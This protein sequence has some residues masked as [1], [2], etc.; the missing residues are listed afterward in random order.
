MLKKVSL[1]LFVCM[2]SSSL[3]ATTLEELIQSGLKH[4]SVI[5]KSDLEIEL[6]HTKKIENQ[7]KKLGSIDLVGSYTHY[8]LPRTLAPIVP[9]ALSPT[10]TIDTTQ[11]L[12]STGIQY[13]VPL[14]TGGL[15]EEQIQ[16]DRLSEKM[17]ESDF[18]LILVI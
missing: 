8:N 10:N 1:L 7:A 14:F 4:N 2:Q 3:F 11:D 13:T 16:I 17:S 18:G 15:L 12:W 9:S 5:Q 6:M